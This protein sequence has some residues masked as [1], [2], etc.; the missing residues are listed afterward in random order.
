[1]N[2]PLTKDKLEYA[3]CLELPEMKMPLQTGTMFETPIGVF[4]AKRVR[5]AYLLAV[6]KIEK[7]MTIDFQC[8]EVIRLL[9]ECFEGVAE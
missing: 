6:E 7:Y 5:S 9:E 1:M 2:E 8:A 3:S 4:R